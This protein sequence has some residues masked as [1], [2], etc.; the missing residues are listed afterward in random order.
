[1]VD[2]LFVAILAAF[3]ALMVLFVSVCERIVGKDGSVGTD[4]VGG[5][6]TDT[7]ADTG[8]DTTTTTEEVPA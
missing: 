7:G 4:Q 8:A 5:L 1:M 2:L 6:T 3:F